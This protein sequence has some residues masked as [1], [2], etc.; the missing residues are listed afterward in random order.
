VPAAIMGDATYQ[1]VF[2]VKT[3]DYIYSVPYVEDDEKIFLF[4]CSQMGSR[5]KT[6]APTPSPLSKR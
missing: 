6:P 5:R 4:S 1:K 2:L 3:E